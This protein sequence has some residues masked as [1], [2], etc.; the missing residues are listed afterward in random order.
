MKFLAGLVVGSVL[1]IFYFFYKEEEKQERAKLNDME[2]ARLRR[3]LGR[4]LKNDGR[5]NPWEQWVDW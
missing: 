3:T 5:P 2:R 4:E 1:T